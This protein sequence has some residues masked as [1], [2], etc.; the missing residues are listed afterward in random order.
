MKG[1]TIYNVQTVEEQTNSTSANINHK[2]VRARPLGLSS[3]RWRFCR[4]I[5]VFKGKYDL[6]KWEEGQ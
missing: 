6:L 5:D 4:A 2:W 3:L 1:I